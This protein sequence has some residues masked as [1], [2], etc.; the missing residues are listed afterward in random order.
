ML[1][2]K[3][4][5]FL[6]KYSIMG[7]ATWACVQLVLMAGVE[8]KTFWQMFADIFGG[9]AAGVT[10]GIAFFVFFG[11]IGWV[12]GA[13]YGALGLFTL[14][15]GGALGGLG[16]GAIVHIARNPDQYIF[17]RPVILI[18]AV[19]SY[20]LVRFITMRGLALYDRYG[21]SVLHDA[22]KRIESDGSA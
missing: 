22:M 9:G 17:N 4:A 11:A 13:L 2:K 12:S 7:A 1:K 8:K 6:V 10:A 20:V 15:V 18:G 21:P 3:I 14:M 19:V 16:L 5:R